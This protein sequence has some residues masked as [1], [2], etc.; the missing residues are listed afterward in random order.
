M[1]VLDKFRLDG[2]VAIVTG[3]GRGLGRAIAIALAEAGA[4][5][6]EADQVEDMVEKTVSE[7]GRVDIGPLVVYLASDASSY[8]TDETIVIDGGILI[9]T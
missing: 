4:D 9:L 6:R 8:M 5:V 7:L 2:K 3:G 1:A